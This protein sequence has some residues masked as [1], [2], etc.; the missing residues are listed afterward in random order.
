MGVGW[1][2]F[3]G[4]VGVGGWVGGGCG[5]GWGGWGAKPAA[6]PR[7]QASMAHLRWPPLTL[8]YLV[9]AKMSSNFFFSTWPSASGQLE[10]S[11]GGRRQPGRPIERT[12]HA[13]LNDNLNRHAEPGWRDC[14]GVQ[15]AAATGLRES[16]RWGPAPAQR[17]LRHTW[18]TKITFSST[19]L[20]TPMSCGTILRGAA[21]DGQARMLGTPRGRQELVPTRPDSRPHTADAAFVCLW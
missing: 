1:A 19:A 12:R 15:A 3:E 9:A 14:R 16:P 13:S 6:K 20:L 10:S 7:G 8:V 17:R 21:G 5:V 4:G 2:G 11:C 18:C